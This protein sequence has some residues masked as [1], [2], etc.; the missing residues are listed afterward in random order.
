MQQIKKRDYKD[1]PGPG[2]HVELLITHNDGRVDTF[3]SEAY[4]KSY[5]CINNAREIVAKHAVCRLKSEMLNKD[6]EQG[7]KKVSGNS[8]PLP[9]PIPVQRPRGAPRKGKEHVEMLNI[10]VKKMKKEPVNYDEIE[11]RGLKYQCTAYHSCF[12][13]GIKGEWRR[14]KQD[15]KQTAA[16]AASDYLAKNSAI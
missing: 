3:K 10:L 8:S 5:E 13:E 9:I 14:S 11:Q 16:E 7:I 15:A 12:P 6:T 2:N 1:L 4:C